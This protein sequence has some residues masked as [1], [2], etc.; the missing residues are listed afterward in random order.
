M[1]ETPPGWSRVPLR[2]LTLPG[3]SFNPGNLE[4]ETFQYIDIEALD[5]ARQVIDKP[6]EL[7]V[8]QAPSR[9]RVLVR[10]GDVLFSLVRP[11]LKNVALISSDLDGQIASTAFCCVRPG[12]GI[13]SRFV[14]NQL[15]QDR[16]ILSIPTYGSSPPAA[17]D[18]E[19][20]DTPVMLA[21]ENEQRRIVAKIEELFSELDAGTTALERVK[22][23]LARFKV[24]VLKAAV[25]GRLTENWREEHPDVESASVL[26]ERILKERR[27]KWEEEQLAKYE[28]KGKKLPTAWRE[29]YQEP[30]KPD[31]GGLPALPAGWWWASVGQV[32]AIQGGIQK[33][34]NRAPKR[35]AYPYLRVANVLMNRLDLQEIEYFELLPGELERLRLETGDLLVVE[36]NGSRDQIGRSALWVGQIADCVHQNHIIRVRPRGIEPRYLNSYWNSPVARR[37]TTEVAAST[38]G[39]YTLSVGKVSSLP[40]PVPPLAEQTMI[41]DTVE[42]Q[43]DSIDQTLSECLAALVR[44]GKMRFGILRSAFEGRLVPQDP[45]DEPA[46]V[47][48]DRIRAERAA[49]A[50]TRPAR[51][52]RGSR[53]PSGVD[54]GHKL[55]PLPFET[56]DPK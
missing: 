32:S 3:S 46:T 40:V 42:E 49:D 11:Y 36:G 4:A 30:T 55:V 24:S 29:K 33:Q 7:A 18:E 45:S 20:F 9:A 13:D 51:K 48:L 47:L 17:R 54:K 21:P 1:S 31:I 23:N 56:L 43:L 53:K 39:L 44:A 8:S 28:A 25:E 38:S 27:K 52:A 6:K 2:E 19:F 34:P 10:S 50:K 22:A 12:P 37:R 5:N 15:C 35:N 26:L 41:A 16:L 14:F